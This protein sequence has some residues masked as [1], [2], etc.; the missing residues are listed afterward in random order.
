M[1]ISR[2]RGH[3]PIRD[4]NA[5][6]HNGDRDR[7]AKTCTP[8]VVE[9]DV[10]DAVEAMAEGD[11][12]ERDVDGDEPGI[13]EEAALDDF[14]RET[15]RSAHFGGEVLDPKVH[16]EQHEQG[17]ACDALKVPVDCASGHGNRL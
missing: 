12:E 17:G 8:G 3:S 1:R 9:A 15:S 2:E 7:R 11:K 6:E 4:D 13:L 10:S 14:E 16:D 5:N